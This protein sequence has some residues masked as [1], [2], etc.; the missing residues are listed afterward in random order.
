MSKGTNQ[1]HKID[2]YI[3]LQTELF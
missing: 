2:I 1:P 3:Y